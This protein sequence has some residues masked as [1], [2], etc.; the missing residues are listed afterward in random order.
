[1]A[2]KLYLKVWPHNGPSAALARS[3]DHLAFVDDLSL[4]R[5]LIDEYS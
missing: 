3:T 1:M 5:K 4:P 2:T